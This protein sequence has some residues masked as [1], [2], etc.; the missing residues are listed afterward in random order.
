MN[1]FLKKKMISRD[2]RTVNFHSVLGSGRTRHT[3]P[4]A[5][6]YEVLAAGRK[7]CQQAAF[8]SS[9]SL[10]LGLRQP[11]IKSTHKELAKVNQRFDIGS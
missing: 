3:Q 1:R 7:G 6:S 11:S 9:S 4:T 2:L 10:A 5:K 8:L